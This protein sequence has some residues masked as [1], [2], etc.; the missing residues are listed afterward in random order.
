MTKASDA[1]QAAQRLIALS[2]KFPTALS[3]VPNALATLGVR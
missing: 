3:W 1:Y 2:A